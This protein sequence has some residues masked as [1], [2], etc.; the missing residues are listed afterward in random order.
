MPSLLDYVIFVLDFF[1][2]L[3]IAYFPGIFFSVLA[4]IVG[5]VIYFVGSKKNIQMMENSHE[6]LMEGSKNWVSNLGSDKEGPSGG[7]FILETKNNSPI[8]HV[9]AHI[10]LI[11]RHL[12]VSLV[13]AKLKKRR[14]RLFIAADPNH[15]TLKRYQI[16][17]MPINNQKRIKELFE[18]LEK[19]DTFKTGNKTLDETLLIKAN[20]IKLVYEIFQQEK[21]LFRSLYTLRD[22]IERIS[23]YP[24]EAPSIRFVALINDRLQQKL[25][26]DFVFNFTEVMTNIAQKDHFIKQRKESLR[27]YR[28]PTL[29]KDKDKRYRI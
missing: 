19:L 8:E 12:M 22:N 6:S 13:A 27:L 26:I 1:L 18:M 3:I 16:E 25:F 2:S 4:I 7:T 17:I 9:K 29:D 21:K 23:F 11:P 14:D 28:D 5:L 20:N 15:E 24:F 10:L